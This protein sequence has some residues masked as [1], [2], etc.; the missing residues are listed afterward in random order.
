LS[1]H[2]NIEG[3]DAENCARHVRSLA[4]SYRPRYLWDYIIPFTKMV[5]NLLAVSFFALIALSSS[6]YWF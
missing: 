4:C 3:F 2:G 6:A 5:P 1:W